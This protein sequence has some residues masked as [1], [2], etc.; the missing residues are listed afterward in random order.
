MKLFRFDLVKKRARTIYSIILS[1]IYGGVI[2]AVLLAAFFQNL[3]PTFH[4]N[5]LLFILFLLTWL[6]YPFGKWLGRKSGLIMTK[7]ISEYKYNF[8]G[9][10]WAGLFVGALLIFKSS[11]IGVLVITV[12]LILFILSTALLIKRKKPKTKI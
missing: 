4:F 1:G 10:I 9:A 3:E 11:M 7:E 2:A 5:L 12:L 6:L 8:F